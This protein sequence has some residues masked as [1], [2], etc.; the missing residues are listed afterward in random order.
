MKWLLRLFLAVLLP[1]ASVAALETGAADTAERSDA[2]FG[3]YL[4][5]DGARAA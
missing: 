3:F 4:G 1:P 2:R 5:P